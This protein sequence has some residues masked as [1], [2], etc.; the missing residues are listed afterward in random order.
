MNQS[1]FA[2]SAPEE[3]IENEETEN[4]LSGREGVEDHRIIRI[5]VP[6]GERPERID[7][8][9][10]RMIGNTSRTKVHE[11]MEAGAVI[12]NGSP[13][14]KPAYKIKGGDEI[15]VHIP[16]PPRMRAEA[17]DIPINIIYEDAALLIINK[18]AGMVVHPAA[19]TR[20][21]TL[22]NA[23]LHHIEDFRAG[24]SD[25][26]SE[27]P[28]I[29][30]RL[31]KDTSGLMVVAKSESSHRN[32]AKQFFLHTAQRTYNAIIW[33]NP[34][35]KFGRIDTLQGR[36][37][38]DRKKFTVVDEGGKQAITDYFVLEEFTGF[39]LVELKLKTGRTHQ[40][41][42][43]LQHLGHPVFGDATYSG[44]ALNV[45]R[46][47]VPHF[48]DWTE[49]LLKLMPRQAL[50]ARSLRLNHPTTGELMEW[51]APLPEDMLQVLAK[52]R[53]MRDRLYGSTLQV[54]SE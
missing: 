7:Q 24:N 14:T 31:D 21:G 2:N 53:T 52:L 37:P 5:S 12:L 34:S 43:H 15:A 47:D 8:F 28:G 11:A 30:H 49:N 22:V 10:A 45:V 4:E 13:V 32:L 35:A 46:H 38:K 44:R 20:S 16:R 48:K 9:L 42:V 29:V 25:S 19:G 50:H 17:E 41:R 6:A 33:G 36:H 39:S 51:S 27:R 1:E 26:Q 18:P 3:Q 40:I 23:L 54:G